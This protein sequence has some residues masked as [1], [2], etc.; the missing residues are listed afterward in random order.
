MEK[1]EEINQEEGLKVERSQSFIEAGTFATDFKEQHKDIEIKMKPVKPVQNIDEEHTILYKGQRLVHLMPR[2]NHL[3][4]YTVT[5]QEDSPIAVDTPQDKEQLTTK[6]EH[7]IKTID[8]NFKLEAQKQR[9]KEEK[10]K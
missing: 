7:M 5:G 1:N 3:F 9:K 2:T 10:A 6:L 4:K 8:A